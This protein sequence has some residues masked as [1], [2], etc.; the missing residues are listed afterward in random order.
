MNNYNFRILASTPFVGDPTDDELL[1]AADA[2]GEAG[3]DDAAV[4]VHAAGLELEFDRSAKSLLHALASA[5]HDVRRAGFAV[6]SIEL[7]PD[8]VL[9]DVPA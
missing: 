1:D 8:A 6:K 9:S 3:C 4:S 5:V 2:L 7:D